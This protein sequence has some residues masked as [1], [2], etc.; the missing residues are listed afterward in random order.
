MQA[1]GTAVV[2]DGMWLRADTL[3]SAVQLFYE[4]QRDIKAGP[5]DCRFN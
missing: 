5:A 3:H 2:S 4:L 1:A